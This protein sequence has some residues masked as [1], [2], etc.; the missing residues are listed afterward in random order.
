MPDETK[1][2]PMTMEQL[3]ALGSLED[4]LDE[5]DWRFQ[6]VEALRRAGMAA[7]SDPAE[8]VRDVLRG[9]PAVM[10]HG[11]DQLHDAVL[12]ALGVP[13]PRSET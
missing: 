11:L 3:R 6:H 13:T 2:V 7:P 4:F 10:N 9:H 1:L 8:A 5:N 12:S